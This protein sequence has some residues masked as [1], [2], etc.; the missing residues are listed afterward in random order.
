MT[1]CDHTHPLAEP[2]DAVHQ[3]NRRHRPIEHRLL[4]LLSLIT[5]GFSPG[6]SLREVPCD[7]GAEYVETVQE[8]HGRAD[9]ELD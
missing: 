9:D 6:E 4:L 3:H 7:R 2:E 1:S 5:H 8:M